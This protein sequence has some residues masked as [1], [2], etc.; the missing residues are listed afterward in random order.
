MADG[1]QNSRPAP[2]VQLSTATRA[3]LCFTVLGLMAV[4]AWQLGDQLSLSGLAAKE[5]WFR[6]FQTDQ[7]VLIYL[8]AFAI[9]VTVAGL[10]LP[11]ATG[12]TLVMA[13]W[14]GFWPGLLL[15]SFGSTT[16][17]TVA[18]LL[19][20]Y[21]LQASVTR[22]FGPRLAAFNQALQSEGPFYLLSLRLIPAVPFFVINAVMGLTPIRVRTFFWI[23]QIGMLPGTAVYVYAG[24]SVPDLQT[25]AD[26]GIAAI[27]TP[28]Q[29]SQLTAAFVLLAVFPLLT[30][31]LLKHLQSRNA[32]RASG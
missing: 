12:M 29:L 2:A 31:K 28:S 17:A 24:A 23:S 21:L 18:F 7:P 19:S 25:L 16:G 27:F 20:R 8:I 6:Q 15:V 5:A 22:R 11:G 14:F 4:A 10:S 9:Y 1:S 13:W 30:R 32:K 3:W 26:K